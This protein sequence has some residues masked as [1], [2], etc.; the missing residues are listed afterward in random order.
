MRMPQPID[1]S[2]EKILKKLGERV[3][4]IRKEKKMT[5]EQVANAIGKD[6]QSI[7][8]LEKGDFSPS[9]IYLLEVCKGLGVSF[10]YLIEGIVE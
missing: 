3:K 6:R 8:R 1:K 9:F 4:T 7:H 2:Q 10:S 5:L